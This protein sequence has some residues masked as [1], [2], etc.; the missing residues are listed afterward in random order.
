MLLFTSKFALSLQKGLGM[1][2]LLL[3]HTCKKCCY[4]RPAAAQ[5]C[6]AASCSSMLLVPMCAASIILFLVHQTFASVSRL[7]S[8]N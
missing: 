8:K 2:D 3:Q 5:A 6:S 1:D 4:R 7:A